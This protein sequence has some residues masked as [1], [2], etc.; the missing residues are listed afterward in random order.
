MFFISYYLQLCFLIFKLS[1]ISSVGCCE[2]NYSLV[3]FENVD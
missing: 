1:S 2:Q 3:V